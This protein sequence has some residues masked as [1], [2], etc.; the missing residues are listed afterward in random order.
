[1]VQEVDR[2]LDHRVEPEVVL[3][4]HEGERVG[5]G[6]RRAPVLGVLMDVTAQ[7]RVLRLI[8]E[9]QVHLGQ[10]DQLDV[11]AAVR[12]GTPAEPLG[13]RQADPSGPGAAD[14]DLQDR[15]GHGH[16]RVG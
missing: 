9:R 15:V 8:E 5:A 7:A 16:S 12:D 4:D 13:H 3:R 14:D 1:M 6:D 2:V 10:V 11:E